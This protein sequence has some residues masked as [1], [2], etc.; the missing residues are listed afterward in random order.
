M[1]F[2]SV[3]DQGVKIL[4][5]R[6]FLKKFVIRK[7]ISIIL[8]IFVLMIIANNVYFYIN[9]DHIL[10]KQNEESPIWHATQIEYDA[11]NI[12]RLIRSL[13]IG[14]DDDDF[15]KLTDRKSVV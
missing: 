7:T 4:Q 13:Y 15:Y 3:S 8:A 6:V 9:N 1:K 11:L 2:I 12:A 10:T 14:Y 5:L